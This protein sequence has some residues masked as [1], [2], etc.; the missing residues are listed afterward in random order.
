MIIELQDI[1]KSFSGTEVLS[2]VNLTVKGG[3]VVALVGENGAGKSTLTRI[4]SGA[5][6]PDS[7]AIII[8]GTPAE[9]KHPQDAMELGIHVIYQEFLHNIF[10]QLTV[11]E[12]LFTLDKAAEFGRFFVNKRKMVQEARAVMKTIGL[13]ADPNALAETLS[14]AEL[15]MLEI[16][17]SLGHNIRMLILD[18]PTAA[19]DEQESERLFEQVESLRRAGICVVYISHRLEEVFRISDRVV[20][21]RN[22]KVAMEGKTEELTE[23]D[24]VSAM[25]GRE[26][27]EFYPKERH[28]RE[29]V[30]LSVRGAGSGD[31]FND[32]SLDVRAGEVVGI[33][34]VFGCGKG[35]VLRTLFGLRPLTSGEVYLAGER[36]TIRN[37]QDAIAAG[38]AYITP[39][40]QAE[41]L[42][43]QQSVSDNI[44]LA[45]LTSFSPGGLMNGAAERKS[46]AEV[47]S[48]LRI[49]TASAGTDVG[50]LSG[51][52]QQ[53]VLFG[54]WVL[55][56]PRVLLMEE[57]TRGVD[58]GAKTEIYRIINE[59][60]ALGVAVIL[61]SS[62]LPELVA[63]SDRVVVMRQGGAVAELSGA[64]LNQQKLLEHALES[65]A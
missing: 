51:G 12:N 15:Q 10:P 55:T 8:D 65:A 61:V 25:V 11:A 32:I 43:L 3:E 27:E 36:I 35:D 52:N 44:S 37:P 9:L 20:V 4:I 2:G 17:K 46:T 62:D 22:G 16:V 57:P 28:T 18:E 38:I 24:V 41:G 6:A 26:V 23:R 45:S 29:D 34:G 7:G 63:M 13:H 42:C 31:R 40:R 56:K 21:L 60:A 64:D 48:G 47:I 14:V 53:K 19:L 1:H 58:I 50:H 54:R 30:V 49:R 59:Q 39:D 5:H 33:G